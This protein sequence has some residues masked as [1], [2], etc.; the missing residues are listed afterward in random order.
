MFS[1]VAPAY[2]ERYGVP[3]DELKAVLARIASKNHFN[4]ARNPRAQFRR[5]MSVEQILGTDRIMIV[6]GRDQEADRA[7]FRIDA[8][9]DFRREP[10]SAS[11][12]TTIA[13]FF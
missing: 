9:V 2:A 7:A 5:E 3:M 1:M 12:H 13:T 11:A 10:A 4:G 6:A 8:R